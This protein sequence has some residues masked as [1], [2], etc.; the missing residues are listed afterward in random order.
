MFLVFALYINIFSAAVHA[1]H[2]LHHVLLLIQ[3]LPLPLSPD[4]GLDCHDAG[5]CHNSKD[6]GVEEHLSYFKH[7]C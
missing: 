3:D 5:G 7:L 4:C 2:L 1:V 6:G